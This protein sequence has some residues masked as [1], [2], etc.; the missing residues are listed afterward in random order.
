[1]A[2]ISFPADSAVTVGNNAF[3]DCKNL[4]EVVFPR[5]GRTDIGVS[6]FKGFAKLANV[7][8]PESGRVTVGASA[9]EGCVLLPE[10]RFPEGSALRI[11]DNAFRDCTAL[12]NVAFPAP[13]AIVLGGSASEACTALENVEF[14]GTAVVTL[15][16]RAF[17]DC[18]RT[19]TV[20]W[21]RTT[22][23]SIG[24][25]AFSRCTALVGSF[26][27]GPGLREG[28][29]KNPLVGCTRITEFV[30]GDH[31]F[32]AVAEGSLYDKNVTELIAWALGAPGS[33]SFPP[34]FATILPPAFLEVGAASG[35]LV[36]PWHVTDIGESV[37]QGVPN[38]TSVTFE[39]AIV[40]VCLRGRDNRQLHELDRGHC[41]IWARRV[42][43]LLG[44]RE[45]HV[46]QRGG[47]VEIDGVAFS[48]YPS[49]SGEFELPPGLAAI[50]LNPFAGCVGITSFALDPNNAAYSASGSMLYGDSE[51]S[52]IAIAPGHDG[53]LA[54]SAATTTNGECAC[55]APKISG[56]LWP[57]ENVSLIGENAFMDCVGIASVRFA[58]DPVTIE[59][60]AFDGCTGRTLAAFYAPQVRVTLRDGVFDAPAITAG[61]F[62]SPLACIV[63]LTPTETVTPSA[64]FTESDNFAASQSFTASA[65]LIPEYAT[66]PLFLSVILPEVIPVDLVAGAAVLGLVLH[67]QMRLAERPPR[68]SRRNQI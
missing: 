62:G 14:L 31:E 24:G 43:G 2:S 21:G 27:L 68:S 65:I 33:I 20:T 35:A 44:S 5:T 38:V 39:C 22:V 60:H 29:G 6:A 32:Y 53:P 40:T 18:G 66:L 41:Q 30:L 12:S 28:I 54:I 59:A 4:E 67:I 34:A 7:S 63:V 57:V 15:G 36:I 46:S 11:G 64:E 8:S 58:A 10:A 9:F 37:F 25:F 26:D 48:N 23:F 56:D 51:G 61:D 3:L 1:M 16:A 19:V 52:L 49:L 55:R 42:H 47:W 17:Q 50:G 13:R 45:L